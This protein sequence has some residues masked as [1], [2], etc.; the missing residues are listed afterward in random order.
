MSAINAFH[1]R[2]AR[3]A[4]LACDGA[5]FSYLD[6]TV[7]E[8][9]G[10]A[11]MFPEHKIVL[12]MTGPNF[13]NDIA[14]YARS[15]QSFN[16]HDT[17]RHIRDAYM[18]VRERL[19]EAA[20]ERE[21]TG[22]NDLTLVAA[23]YLGGESRPAIYRMASNKNAIGDFAV[24]EWHEIP[25]VFIPGVAPDYLI[26]R[27][28]HIED[29]VTD[30]RELFRT[31]RKFKF[32]TIGGVAVGGTCTLYRVGPDGIRAW[33]VLQFADRVGE[34]PSLTESGTDILT[35]AAPN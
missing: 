11:F 2:D 4:Y 28:L 34:L 12:A 7:I 9:T 25:G 23:I 21:A 33:D 30:T 17:L 16:Q 35:E 10:K 29:A 19:R 20:P 26:A 13:G 22:G 24:D 31:Q 27:G 18:V 6:G 14:E 3:F 5:V 8:L 32:E 1:D 15:Q